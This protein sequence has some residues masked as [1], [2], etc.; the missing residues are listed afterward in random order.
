MIFCPDV[1]IPDSGLTGLNNANIYVYI[2]I[3][4]Y[5]NRIWHKITI[6]GWYAIKPNNLTYSSMAEAMFGLVCLFIGISTFMG[7]LMS[8]SFL[9]KNSSDTIK[10]IAGRELQASCLSWG[11]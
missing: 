7:Y 9:L 2:Y 3:Y 8:K 1:I 6:K 4:I 10:S 5:E 11:Y